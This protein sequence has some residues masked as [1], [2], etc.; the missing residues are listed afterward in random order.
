M[1]THLNLLPWTCRR[2][3]MI[4]VRA[5]RWAAVW[6]AVSLLTLTVFGFRMMRYRA[7]TVE[8]GRLQEQAAPLEQTRSAIGGLRTR[9]G[10]LS[11][12]EMTLARLATPRPA[13]T[14][15]G[16]ISRSVSQCDGLVRVEQLTL[17]TIEE[18]DKANATARP[19]SRTTVIIKGIALDNLAASRFVM[20]LRNSHSFDRVE[21]KSSIEEPASQRKMC[22]YLVECGY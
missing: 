19:V 7:A 17:Q 13:L 18:G 6:V 14:L 22:A 2:N 15:L 10:D 8:L 1:K 16:L 11:A 5:V 21:L 3:A 9:L 12:Q 4:R 20:A